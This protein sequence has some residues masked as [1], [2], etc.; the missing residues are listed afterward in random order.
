MPFEKTGV[1]K[2]NDKVAFR[3]GFKVKGSFVKYGQ[4]LSMFTG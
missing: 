3:G 1:T 2:E 4:Y